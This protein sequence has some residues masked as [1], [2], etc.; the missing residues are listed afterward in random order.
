MLRRALASLKRHEPD[1]LPHTFVIDDRSP[2][3][4]LRG[5]I[6]RLCN[7]FNCNLILKIVNQGYSRAVNTGIKLA[8]RKEYTAVL[9]MNSDIEVTTPFLVQVFKDFNEGAYVI[10]CKLLYPTGRIQSAGFEIGDDGYPFEYDKGLMNSLEAGGYNQRRYVCGV[11]GAFQ[12]FRIDREDASYSEAYSLSYEDVEFCA[13]SWAQSYPVLYDPDI[14][15]IHSESSTRTYRVGARE[16]ESMK[17]WIDVDSKAFNF[18]SIREK[19]A[20][21]NHG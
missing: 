19:I 6:V 20:K 10:G 14:V 3:E 5:E 2:L 12:A 9:T 21:L 11:T 17:R 1:L 7:E 4:P 8:R 13:R 15:V 16:F 18:K